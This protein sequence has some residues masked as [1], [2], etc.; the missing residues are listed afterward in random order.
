MKLQIALKI[1]LHQCVI[2]KAKQNVLVKE[3]E[4]YNGKN[5]GNRTTEF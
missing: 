5:G 4:G 1:I 2:E 3:E